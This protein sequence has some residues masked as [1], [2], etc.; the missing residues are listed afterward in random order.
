MAACLRDDS[1]AIEQSRNAIKEAVL[2]GQHQ[3]DVR[4]SDIAQRREPSIE[5]RVQ[6]LC[7]EVRQIGHRRLR[8]ADDVQPC[9]INLNM[10]IDQPGH[11][12]AT[13]AVD[14]LILSGCGA[15]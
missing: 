13:A 10:G 9:R 8:N 15:L 4:A 1:A 2:D 11:Q 5:A 6:K 3:A 12:D 14:D 7:R